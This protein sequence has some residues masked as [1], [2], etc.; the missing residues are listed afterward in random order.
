MAQLLKIHSHTHWWWGP[1]VSTLPFSEL[2]LLA[3]SQRLL[4]PLAIC[5]LAD[6]KL[7]PALCFY[8]RVLTAVSRRFHG[9][10]RVHANNVL[11]Q[12]PLTFLSPPYPHWPYSSLAVPILH[13]CILKKKSRFPLYERNNIFL[14][15]TDLL[16]YPKDLQFFSISSRCNDFILWL[17]RWVDICVYISQYLLISGVP[18]S[19]IGYCDYC[20]YTWMCRYLSCMLT[21]IPS[22][23]EWGMIQQLYV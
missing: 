19:I 3:L 6:L 5:T 4:F 21:Q 2:F 12:S 13:F 22:E 8:Q 14:Y 11:S 9:D 1:P 7:L 10:T 23:I 17:S 16:F 20:S 15:G 18:E